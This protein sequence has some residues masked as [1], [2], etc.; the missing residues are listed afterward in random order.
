MRKL[1]EEFVNVRFFQNHVTGLPVK[2]K[3]IPLKCNPV[4]SNYRGK[5][6]GE[7]NPELIRAFYVIFL[8]TEI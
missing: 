3:N 5:G 6:F 4:G 8:G 2:W 7:S 1:R